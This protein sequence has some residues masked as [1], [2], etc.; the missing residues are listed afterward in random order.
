MQVHQFH[1]FPPPHVSWFSPLI[2]GVGK[3]W[4]DQRSERSQAKQCIFFG[5]WRGVEGVG[6]DP[7]PLG[8]YD[9]EDYAQCRG[10]GVRSGLQSI[11]TY[12]QRP[13]WLVLKFEA[14]DCMHCLMP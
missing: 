2:L 3:L 11:R 13:G 8:P 1:L 5:G 4:E 6:M 14:R 7:T 9:K 12:A 10:R